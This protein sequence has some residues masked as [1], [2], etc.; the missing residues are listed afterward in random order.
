MLRPLRLNSHFILTFYYCFQNS[1]ILEVIYHQSK[2]LDHFR[3]QHL[4]LLHSL[5]RSSAVLESTNLDIFMCLCKLS[6]DSD[7]CNS[8]V[9]TFE[10][11]FLEISSCFIWIWHDNDYDT[12]RTN[13]YY[14][15][16]QCGCCC[17]SSKMGGSFFLFDNYN[18][19]NGGNNDGNVII[20]IPMRVSSGIRWW[21]LLFFYPPSVPS[22]IQSTQT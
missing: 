10:S 12:K 11:T 17:C 8:I 19:S 3:W 7:C 16:C 9:S 15:K 20:I 6:F 13:D 4:Y 22:L 21:E 1:W 5:V 2:T 14:S 18:I